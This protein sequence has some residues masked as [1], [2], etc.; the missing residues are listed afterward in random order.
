[1]Q[2]WMTPA[3]AL[4]PAPA[5]F[6]EIP[7]RLDWAVAAARDTGLPLELVAEGSLAAVDFAAALNA[8]HPDG[9]LQRL[10]EAA[11]PWRARLDSPECPVSATTPEA[12]I[13]AM[14]STLFAL[15]TVMDGGSALALVRPPG[16]HATP[17]LAMGFCYVN[18]V[19]IAARHA[20]RLGRLRVAILDFDVHH[21]NGTQDAF[22]EDDTVFFCS[23]H[24]DPRTQ[25]PGTGFRHER[26]AGAGLGHTL[27]L[28]LL[29]GSE[30]GAYLTELEGIALPALEMYSPELLLISAGFDT[31]RDDPLG[32]LG[33]VGADYRRMGEGLGRLV[34]R[35]GI[36]A[37]L[38]LEGG[39]HPNCFQDGL[40]PFLLGWQN[41]G[42]S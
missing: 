4:H 22:Y 9:R 3:S 19:A 37:L 25:Y 32:G 24:E 27:N 20:Q 5:G 26:G 13:A 42:A 33:L 14:Q 29:T 38:V 40:R 11:I 15:E 23:L 10:Q 41:A 30:G 2:V 35:L 36:P 8:V 7:E 16:H 6:P 34:V 12:V 28:T 39:Y 18:N 31:H 1:M 17:R 21:G